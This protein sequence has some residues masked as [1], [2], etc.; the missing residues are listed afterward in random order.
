MNEKDVR[1]IEN[2][3]SAIFDL[4][5]DVDRQAPKVRKSVGYATVFI[6][7]W[8]IINFLVMIVFLFINLILFI[9][10]MAL[11]IVGILAV[12]WLRELGSFFSYYVIRHRA[13]KSLR[14]EDPI[15]YIPKG[16][17]SVHRLLT[18]L[19]SKNPHVQEAMRRPGLFRTQAILRG[20]SGVLYSFDGYLRVNSSL[21]W[22][23]FGLGYPGYSL[24][25]K[26]YEHPPRLLEMQSLKNAV[27][28][29]ANTGPVPPCRVIAVWMAK[30]DEGIEDDVYSFVTNE[31]IRFSHL[32][33]KFSCTL[34]IITESEDGTYD[35][36]PYVSEVA[37]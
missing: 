19:A 2:P 12:K 13:I 37:Y 23:L 31:V 1:A 27:E 17:D 29:I 36:I 33:N 30:G 7:I 5:E 22:R 34:E 11:F 6:V 21:A 9:L 15:V 32:G 24:F 16:E 8:L 28:D 4:A 3:I 35:F 18:Y 10:F 26:R 14:E 20:R 25:I